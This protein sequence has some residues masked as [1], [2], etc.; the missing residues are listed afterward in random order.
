ME[1]S[2]QQA[3][4]P[5]PIL[6][7]GTDL[8]GELFLRHIRRDPAAIYRVVG[9][10]DPSSTERGRHIFN[11]PVFPG[12]TDLI[13]IVKQLSA[14]GKRP[15]RFVLTKT[16]GSDFMRRILLVAEM[17]Q[18]TICRL[19]HFIEFRQPGEVVS[20]TPR[21]ISV[22]ELIGR[23]EARL[24]CG[25]VDA[26][27]RGRRVLITG[28]GGSIGA[29]LVHQLTSCG[30]D[31]I[32]IL[33][34]SEY[35]LY[36][37]EQKMTSDLGPSIC[38]YF[39]A[40]IRD[41]RALQYVFETERPEIVFHAAALKHVPIVEANPFEGFL[42]N[43]RGTRNVA[44]LAYQYGSSTFVLISTD[45]AVNPTSVMGACKRL[46]ELYIQ[47]LD[48]GLHESQ[49]K[50]ALDT[51]FLTVRFGNVLGSSGSVVPLFQRQL[52]HGGPLT[53]THPEIE[54][55]FMTIREAVELI[56]QA[57]AYGTRAEVGRGQIFV[58]DMG[59]PVRI[60]DVARQMIRLAGLTPDVD[61]K[62]QF[63]GLRSGEKMF[64]ELFADNEKRRQEEI[65]GI[66]TAVSS[67][68]NLVDIVNHLSAIDAAIERGDKDDF[69]SYLTK[70]VPEYRTSYGDEVICAAE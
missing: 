66:L 23:R 2:K 27:V 14:V 30:P 5:L 35:N 60:V 26:F 69:Y 29:E 38:K 41:K 34:N 31:K 47:S 28:G 1:A 24:N 49:H 22:E 57:A 33:D 48:L 70:V 18:I 44:D 3:L 61:V 55:Y 42:T 67:V 6:L 50:H 21:P 64:E 40:D 62:I 9:V 56:L 20:I 68:S 52:L 45:K 53:V 65:P 37:V 8:M 13:T 4:G 43:F 12:E 46:A 54:R 51:R 15:T 39:L 25:V 10:I 63:V 19:P 32:V 36:A 7:I 11:V 16:Y 58:L 17:E 59:P